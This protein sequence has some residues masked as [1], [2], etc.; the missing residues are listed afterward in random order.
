ME[1]SWRLF[2]LF[3]FIFLF[4][5]G[6]YT[7]QVPRFCS[8]Y[9]LEE[10]D[11]GKDMFDLALGICYIRI[12]IAFICIPCMMYVTLR[13]WYKMKIKLTPS[14]HLLL[15]V[16]LFGLPKSQFDLE[17]VLPLENFKRPIPCRLFISEHPSFHYVSPT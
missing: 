14:L 11:K 6:T 12:F 15:R 3:F 4:D 5:F 9:R 8:S 10:H 1:S 17:R 7:T 13:N 2:E 16:F